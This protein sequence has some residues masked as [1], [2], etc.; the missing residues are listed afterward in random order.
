V[1][2]AQ[3]TYVVGDDYCFGPPPTTVGS[4]AAPRV[5]WS[6]LATLSAVLLDENGQP[7]A[8]K[9]LAFQ[10]DDGKDS[11]LTAITDASGRASVRYGSVVV[12]AAR[13]PLSVRFGGDSGAGPSSMTGTLEVSPE[14]V[15]FDSLLVT[16]P[17]ATTRLITARLLDD[18]KTAVAGARVDW[19]INGKRVAGN[20]T[21]KTGR[22]QLRTAKPGQTVQARFLGSPGT[23]AAALSKATRV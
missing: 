14:A 4:L 7:L 20:L 19:W 13:Y 16:K 5:Q 12:P 8:G 21:D 22:A 9:Q 10:L 11:T 15:S 6:D 3:A 23:L 1:P 18:D 17:S 2:P